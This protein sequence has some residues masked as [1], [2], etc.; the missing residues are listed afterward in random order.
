MTRH[1]YTLPEQPARKFVVGWGNPTQ[2][3]FA[4]CL[5]IESD[6][7]L[8]ETGFAHTAQHPALDDLRAALPDYFVIPL[9]L[10]RVLVDE[11]LN[12]DP[13][14]PLLNLIREMF[15]SALPS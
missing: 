3:Y 12:A 2:T 7:V 1:T 8:F 6:A 5:D 9:E 15:K 4:E 13:P 14:T 11:R 10:Q